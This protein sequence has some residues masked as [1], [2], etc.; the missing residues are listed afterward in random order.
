MRTSRVNNAATRLWRSGCTD[1]QAISPFQPV[2]ENW[3]AVTLLNCNCISAESPGRRLIEEIEFSCCL[4]RAYQK[5]CQETEPAKNAAATEEIYSG[6]GGPVAG[7]V[8]V[9]RER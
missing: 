3:K 2:K 4:E 5:A 9:K 6:G 8:K 7:S 1:L